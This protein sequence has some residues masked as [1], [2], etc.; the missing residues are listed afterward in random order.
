MQKIKEFIYLHLFRKCPN[1]RFKL[2]KKGSYDE[3]IHYY[4][5]LKC[6]WGNE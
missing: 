4:K 3:L 5:C 6:G 2:T 1:C